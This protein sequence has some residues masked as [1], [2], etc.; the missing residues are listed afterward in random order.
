MDH[1][2]F[3]TAFSQ[4]L[5]V[6]ITWHSS[7]CLAQSLHSPPDSPDHMAWIIMPCPQPSFISRRWQTPPTIECG[8]S[9]GWES[10]PCPRNWKH[11]GH[12][13]GHKGWDRTV[14]EGMV[15][16]GGVQP[17]YRWTLDIIDIW[18]V[19]QAN[20]QNMENLYIGCNQP[21]ILYP[22]PDVPCWAYFGL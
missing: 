11:T 12:V 10:A 22:Q 1:H 13:R 16:G 4:L 19:R 2:V 3:S 9:T 15:L 17:A 5:I 18:S 8:R 20:W 14:M 21:G 7:S 6:L